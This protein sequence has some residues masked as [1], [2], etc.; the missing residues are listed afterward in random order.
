MS[1]SPKDAT[2]AMRLTASRYP[3]VDE[4]TACTQRSFKTGKK[5]AK[6]KARSRTRRS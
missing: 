6:K 3:G 4:G 2:A 5:V 1:T